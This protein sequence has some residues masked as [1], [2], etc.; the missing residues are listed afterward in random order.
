M[1][2]TTNVRAICKWCGINLSPSHIGPCPNCGK[3]GKNVSVV[4]NENIRLKD[5][6][7]IERRRQ[8]LESNP[9]IKWLTFVL[10]LSSSLI[11]LINLPTVLGILISLVLGMISWILGPFVITRIREIIRR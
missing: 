10:T 4:L 2:E 9:K 1:N 5:S 3:E 6:L 11:T 7:N 8:F